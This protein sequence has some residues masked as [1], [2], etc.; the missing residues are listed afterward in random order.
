MAGTE[1][2][3][4]FGGSYGFFDGSRVLSPQFSRFV[5]LKDVDAA[6]GVCVAAYIVYTRTRITRLA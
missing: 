5:S 1:P 3:E 2:G 6:P 4:C